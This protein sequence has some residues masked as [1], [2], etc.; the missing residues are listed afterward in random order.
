MERADFLEQP[1]LLV[2]RGHIASP[3]G[4][5][6]ATRRRGGGAPGSVRASRIDFS[7]PVIDTTARRGRARGQRKTPQACRG[8]CGD[9]V[10]TFGG[11]ASYVEGM[12]THYFSSTTCPS[13][14][15]GARLE[16]GAARRAGRSHE[17]GPFRR[18]ERRG[19]RNQQARVRPPAPSRARVPARARRLNPT[20]DGES[21]VRPEPPANRGARGCRAYGLG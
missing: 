14:Q 18:R 15:S 16:S 12:E 3:R 10:D 9:F 17:R 8:N 19:D 11:R 21:L 7:L 2:A 4:E 13:R 1:R 5:A 20:R 6:F